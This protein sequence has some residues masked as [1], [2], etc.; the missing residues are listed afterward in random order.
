MTTIKVQRVHMQDS[1]TWHPGN[2]AR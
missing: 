1:Y 2:C